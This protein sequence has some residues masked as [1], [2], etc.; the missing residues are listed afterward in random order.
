VAPDA[1]FVKASALQVGDFVD[2]VS[3]AVKGPPEDPTARSVVFYDFSSGLKTPALALGTVDVDREFS[4]LTKTPPE[5]RISLVPATL[6]DWTVIDANGDGSA[7]LVALTESPLGFLITFSGD[8]TG[9]FTLKSSPLGAENSG[10][11][12]VGNLGGTDRGLGWLVGS[13]KGILASRNTGTGL[14][15]QIT[16]VSYELN[17][18]T[19][20]AKSPFVEV[21]LT[22]DMD[23]ATLGASYGVPVGE[24]D[25]RSFDI[26]APVQNPIGINSYLLA[27]PSKDPSPVTKHQNF[28][29]GYGGT[30]GPFGNGYLGN[31]MDYELLVTAGSG[32]RGLTGAGGAGGIVG[33]KL[34]NSQGVVR[35]SFDVLLPNTE[36]HGYSV[37]FNSGHGGRGFLNGGAGGSIKG[38]SVEYPLEVDLLASTVALRAG[39]GG[40]SATGIGGQGGELS[41]FIVESGRVFASGAGGSGYKGG[42]GGSIRG[43]VPQGLDPIVA[44]TSDPYVFAY[45]G[46][47]GSG[48]SDGGAGGSIV[49]LKAR[50]L[51]VIGGERGQMDYVAGDGGPSVSGKGGAGGSVTGS[52]P[53]DGGNNLGGTVYLRAG[54][55]GKGASGGD[56]GAVSEFYNQPT[57]GTPPSAL[58]ITAGNGG[59]GV[60]GSGGTGGTVSKV[61]AS[62]KG[63]G[64]AFDEFGFPLGAYLYNRIL[65]GNGGDSTGANGGLGG[66]LIEVTSSASGSSLVAAAGRGGDGLAVGGLGG[67]VAGNSK[68]RLSLNAAGGAKLLV[69]AGDG[70]NAAAAL[71]SD[72][73]PL[74]YGPADGKA[75][76]GGSIS[77][78]TQPQS[79]S[80][81]VDLIAGNGGNTPNYGTS[82]SQTGVGNGGSITHVDIAGDI[83]NVSASVAIKSYNN[84]KNNER[85]ADFVQA[86]V[87]EDLSADLTDFVGNVGIVVGSNGRVRDNNQDGLLDP[88]GSGTT[89]VLTDIK[90]R[91]LMSAVAGSVDRINSIREVSRVTSTQ[92]T[93]AVYGADKDPTGPVFNY[94]SADAVLNWLKTPAAARP[95]V[96]QVRPEIGGALV[97]G[98]IIHSNAP[99]TLGDRDFVLG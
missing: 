62:A 61:N 77:Y 18:A 35:G 1:P 58:N 43:N 50:F 19:S 37:G 27:A 8:G 78:L 44:N 68:A 20:L 56:G 59:V 73:D 4:D 70:G 14:M 71:R 65:A 66:S 83:G 57:T 7:D 40:D 82:S 26:Y 67:S 91:N 30:A 13:T 46:D 88:S 25:V 55:G 39:S 98:A 81:R 36:E 85:I 99:I 75:G 49:N 86:A 47:G 41:D 93:G 42:A 74:A 29:F 76:N 92:G 3:F 54:D 64:V 51:A 89:G 38:L 22:P 6:Q 9:N 45:A 96:T 2:R 60:S 23:A 53:A 17:L 63:V 87:R 95:T 79:I 15:D 31:Q 52:S 28:I 84:I 34:V 24:E 48:L 12:V 69:I 33:D 16:L 72:F 97:D 32:G 10:I 90:F 94:I 11:K 21:R 5:I 80:T